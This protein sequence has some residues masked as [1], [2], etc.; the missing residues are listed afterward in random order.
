MKKGGGGL[1]SGKVSWR[2]EEEERGFTFRWG[3]LAGDMGHLPTT[4]LP[5]FLPPT[6][7]PTYLEGCEGTKNVQGGRE[8]ATK[9]RTARHHLVAAPHCLA[10]YRQLWP[11]LATSRRYKGCPWRHLLVG[12]PVVS[13]AWVWRTAFRSSLTHAGSLSV[14]QISPEDWRRGSHLAVILLPA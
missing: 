13:W 14:C 9:G 7:L 11:W 4:N 6:D 5:T 12:F 1:P 2:E 3:G 10:T 8:E